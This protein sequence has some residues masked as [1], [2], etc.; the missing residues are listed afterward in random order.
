ME[1]KCYRLLIRIKTFMQTINSISHE[2]KCQ[3]FFFGFCGKDYLM[4]DG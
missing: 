2:I 3:H 4:V 1:K